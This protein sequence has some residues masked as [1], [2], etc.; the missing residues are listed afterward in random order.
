MA[1]AEIPYVY[2]S[3]YNLTCNCLK[4]LLNAKES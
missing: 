1:Q 4:K 3:A 2:Q